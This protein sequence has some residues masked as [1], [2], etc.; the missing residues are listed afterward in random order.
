ML[1][2]TG[3]DLSSYRLSV[4]DDL[5]DGWV[6]SISTNGGNSD[7]ILDLESDFADQPLEGNSHLREFDLNTITMIGALREKEIEL[8]NSGNIE[9]EADEGFFDT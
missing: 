2:N 1:N 9:F 8:I 3:N 5:P 7:T 6:A 4:L